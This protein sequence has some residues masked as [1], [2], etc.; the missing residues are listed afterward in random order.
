VA[1]REL[2]AE[3]DYEREARAMAMFK[4]LLANDPD[5]YGWKNICQNKNFKYFLVPGVFSQLSTK[6]VMTA[7]FVEGKSVDLCMDEPK[8]VFNSFKLIKNKY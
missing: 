5:Y 3:C 2:K 7:E 4:K 1:R 8:E 6:Q